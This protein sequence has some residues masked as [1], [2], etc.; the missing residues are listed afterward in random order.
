MTTSTDAFLVAHAEIL[1]KLALLQSIA[2]DHFDTN[3]D[4]IGWDNVGSLNKVNH[5]L[6]LILEFLGQ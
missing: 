4:A 3:P 1:E 5:D 2:D 6:G